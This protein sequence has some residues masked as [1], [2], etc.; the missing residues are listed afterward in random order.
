MVK[1][2]SPKPLMGVRFPQPL[3]NIKAA[4]LAAFIFY[5]GGNIARS[6]EVQTA[7]I[8]RGGYGTFT[9]TK[10]WAEQFTKTE[11]NC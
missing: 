10:E 6:K 5:R 11:K 2:W 4:I 9:I 7:V 1:R 8:E 3:Q